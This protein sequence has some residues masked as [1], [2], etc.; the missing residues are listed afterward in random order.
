MNSLGTILIIED[1]QEVAHLVEHELEQA[2]YSVEIAAS[3]D[4]GLARVIRIPV[5]VALTALRLPSAEEIDKKAGLD[6]IDELHAVNPHLPIILMTAHHTTEIAIEATQRGAYDYLT[7]PIDVARLL[8]LIGQAVASTRFVSQ[9][10]ELGQA[11]STKDALVGN[12]LA[13]QTVYKEIGRLADKPV[14][15]LIRGETGT[16]KELV[17]RALFQHCDRLDQPFIVV[18]CVTIPETLLESELFGHEQG[19][20]TGALARRIGRFE[21]ANHGTIFLDE[22]GDMTL[23]SQSSLLR[24][25]QEKTIQRLAGKETIPVDVRIIAATHRDLEQAIKDGSFRED[26]YYRLNVAVI[27]VPPLRDRLEDIPDLTRYFLQR[28][29]ANLG[30]P[31]ATIADDALQFLQQQPWPGNVRELENV[32]RKALLSARGYTLGLDNVRQ[33]LTPPTTPPLPAADQ[34]M[35][36]YVAELLKRAARGELE[37]A[38]GALAEA[39]ERELYAQAIQLAEGNQ[40]KAAQWLGVS[41]P[42]MRTKLTQYGLHPAHEDPVV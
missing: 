19:A 25:L 4:A 5:D 6:L 10:V 31:N 7:K 32:T 29:G 8:V 16:G 15:V 40:A 18:S 23:K 22:I 1:D 30:A 20:F 13:M 34:T 42:T 39:S 41:R 28:H 2:G 36:G 3:A 9:P 11:T 27:N 24:V 21:Q 33:A 12:S 14:T 17:A 37:N 26:L 38:Q 35:A